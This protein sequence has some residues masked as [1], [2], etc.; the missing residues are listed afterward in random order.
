LLAHGGIGVVQEP[1]VR[2]DQ[3]AVAVGLGH[4]VPEALPFGR[5]Q[6]A[7]IARDPFDL[8]A[9]RRGDREQDYL[10]DAIGMRLAVHQGE[11]RAP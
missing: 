11:R 8:A 10:G 9:G 2:V 3:A 5:E 4:A 6:P 7:D 1:A